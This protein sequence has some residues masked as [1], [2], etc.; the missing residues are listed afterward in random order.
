MIKT[1]RPRLHGIFMPWFRMFA[2][3]GCFVSASIF[4]IASAHAQEAQARIEGY[5]SSVSTGLPIARAKVTL[6]PAFREALTDD[7][8]YYA[9][10]NVAPGKTVVTVTYIGFDKQTTEMTVEAGANATCNFTL[11]LEHTGPRAKKD[12][13]VILLEKYTVVADQT[14]TAQA[15]AMNEQRQAANIK[16]VV[17]F[18][19]LGD[20]GMENIGNYMRFM[21]GVVVM[22]GGD[23][24]GSIALGGFPAEMSNIQL[25]GAEMASTGV[26]AT[27]T[28]RLS[29]QDV[30]M[31]NIERIEVSKVP[32]PDMAASGLGGSV[33][34]VSKSLL[35]MRSPSFR[36]QMYMNFNFKDGIDLSGGPRQLTNPTSP[37]YKQPSFSANLDVPLTKWL[38]FS[39]G[40]SK[41]WNQ[42]A[43][44]DTV[45]ES[46]NWLL[47]P[48]KADD[49]TEM[50]S[51]APLSAVYAQPVS[52]ASTENIMAGV[53]LKISRNDVFSFGIQRRDTSDKTSRYYM[54]TS[55]LLHAEGTLN[56]GPNFSESGL[57]RGEPNGVVTIGTDSNL[58][59]ETSTTH[60][61]AQ[62]KHTGPRWRITAN[63]ARSEAT[64]HR[65]G[66]DNGYVPSVTLRRDG[67][68]VRGEGFNEGESIL[69]SSYSFKDANGDPLDF[70]PY[71]AGNYRLHTVN[72]EEYGIYKTTMDSARLDIERLFGY[73]FSIKAGGAYNRLIKDDQRS[74]VNYTYYGPELA[75]SHNLFED[76]LDLKINGQPV[77]WVSPVKVQQFFM[78]NRENTTL[79]RPNN[80][81]DKNRAENSK[82]MEEGISAGYLRFD[83][84]LFRSRLKITGGVRY[85]K[86]ELDGWSMRADETRIYQR[87]GPGDTGAFKR[88]PDG[89]LIKKE[90]PQYYK[91]NNM[92]S[93]YYESL[94]YAERDLHE[95]QAYEGFYPSLNANFAITENLVLRAAYAKTIGR[96]DVRYVVSGLTI[97]DPAEDVVD[98]GDPG[99]ID[100]VDRLI[101]P[102]AVGNP[103][104][105]PWTANSYHISLD[106]YN[107]KGGFGSIG[108]YQKYVTN[109]FAQKVVALD[110]ATLSYYGITDEVKDMLLDPDRKYRLRRWENVGDGTLSGLELSYRQSLGPIIPILDGFQVWVNYTHLKVGGKDKENF[111][112]FAPDIFSCG[113]N[114]IK[115]RY[116]I[117]L[118]CSYQAETK[119]SDAVV[120]GQNSEMWYPAG[121]YNY[122]G[123]YTKYDVNA[124]YSLAKQLT[125]YVSWYNIFGKDKYT[126]RYGPGTPDYA[127]KVGRTAVPS[128][129]TIGIKGTF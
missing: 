5:V 75:S 53:E 3:L 95:S 31:V 44:R 96:P 21:P 108:I 118:L 129:F 98:A 43:S 120:L 79:F 61:T 87:E 34:I 125:L 114:Y 12:D 107:I 48:V 89:T 70:D 25:D 116:A 60:M 117:R 67:I 32:T 65:D 40:A 63:G 113:I 81:I 99:I 104:L 91:D 110:E 126:Y 66:L 109:F 69:P 41:T 14:L 45:N 62:Y 50:R 71:D 78:E 30:P 93:L 6:G 24:A 20:Q 124:E 28:R 9:F 74:M 73:Y 82:R 84:N 35:G 86:T 56:G 36:Y 8:G 52:V 22:S 92:S 128:T 57:Y 10:T 17:A 39:V 13:D 55:F 54:N 119:G 127:S 106:S 100:P 123:A 49:G 47:V 11:A 90:V 105:Q 80:T 72:C 94:K 15:I 58:A 112:G 83:L 97:S 38:A 26:G 68:T 19:E 18:E 115:R 101:R 42:R 122:Q 111:T 23:D 2:F 29:I 46:T 59:H 16:N 7:E 88:N 64:R 33:N 37:K 77:R 27:S 102:V 85:E 1:T 121:T 103:K 76:R 4:E 51:I